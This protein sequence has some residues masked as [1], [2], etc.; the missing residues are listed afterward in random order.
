M[1]YPGIGTFTDKDFYDPVYRPKVVLPQS[2]EVVDPFIMLYTDK[3]QEDLVFLEYNDTAENY[4]KT[5]FN[6]SYET[7]IIVHGFFDNSAFGP[8]MEKLKDTYLDTGDYNVI[9][10]DW[11]NGEHLSY[12]Q[13]MLFFKFIFK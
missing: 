2:P 5:N 1:T 9:I 12:V 7:K 4:M 8:W 3:H 10:I 11:Q 13:V 6:S